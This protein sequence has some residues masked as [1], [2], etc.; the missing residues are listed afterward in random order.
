MVIVMK[1]ILMLVSF[2]LLPLN[3]F[4][5]SGCSSIVMDIDSGRVLY[6]K[7]ANSKNLI[8]STTKIMTAIVT[9]ENS[10]LDRKLVVGDEILEM[11]GTNIYLE[12]GE[13]M[14]VMDLLYGLMLRSG[15][16]ASVVLA[17][18]I[19]KDEKE[20]VYKMNEKA[21]SLGM[22]NSIFCNPHGLDEETK[23]YSTAYDMAILAKYAYQNK[24]YR[25]IISTKK[26]TIKSNLK[27]YTWYNRMSL[28][29]SYKYCIGGKNGYT[30]K[31]GK[32][33]VSYASN[34]DLNLLI[35]SLDDSDIYDNHKSLYD[36]CF[37]KYKNYMIIDKKNFTIDR[38]FVEKDIYIKKS[39]IYPLM[40][41]ELSKIS[42]VIQVDYSNKSVGSVVVKF[43]SKEIGRLKI[44]SKEKKK[45]DNNIF[46]RFI[47]LFV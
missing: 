24:I 28:I 36:M 30:P 3:V 21:K 23:N 46:R 7:N 26:Y 18:N 38:S 35:V 6:E 17:K 32:S 42:T 15:N 8:A 19:F 16:D 44:Y 37:K 31:A 11:Y 1:K 34:G 14:T 22:N 12:V 10:D 40:E 25:K 5:D 47:Q 33:L 41:D 43:N 2:L 29:N 4:A 9:I 27:S 45:K 13:E 39:F 20:F